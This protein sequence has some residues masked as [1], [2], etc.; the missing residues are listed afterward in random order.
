MIIKKPILKVYFFFQTECFLMDKFIKN[1]R[2]LELVTSLS[3]GHE[4]ISKI[5]LFVLYYLTKFDD[6]M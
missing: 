5:L 4:T 2:S 1:K 6:I 3:S